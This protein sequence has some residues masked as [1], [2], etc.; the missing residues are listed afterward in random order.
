M[1]QQARRTVQEH[2][3]RTHLNKAEPYT[4]NICT[5]GDQQRSNT[6]SY[7]DN[8]MDDTRATEAAVTFKLTIAKIFLSLFRK[9]TSAQGAASKWNTTRPSLNDH[10]LADWW[11]PKEC[12]TQ[13]MTDCAE[14]NIDGATEQL[15]DKRL[16][17]NS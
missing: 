8:K 13:G 15:N 2:H 17:E 14:L 11:E 10:Q 7:L 16:C 12:M 4:Y 3:D 9:K 6:N 5:F 1:Q